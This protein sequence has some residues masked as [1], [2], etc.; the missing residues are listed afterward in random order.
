MTHPNPSTALARVV[1]DEMANQGVE[2]VVISPGSR[3]AAVAI[4]ASGD[5]SVETI[6]VVD[7]RSAA[8]HALGVARATGRP[9]AVLSTS[10]T[11]P[12]NFFPAIVEADMSCVPMVVITADRPAEMQGLGANQTIDQVE[13]FGGKVRAYS[14][15]EAPD[16]SVDRNA[17]WR[18][19][20]GRVVSAARGPR[21]GPAHLNVRFREPTVPVTDDGRTTESEYPFPTPRVDGP[22]PGAPMGPV[23]M[24]VLAP[25]RGIVIAGD[26][27]YDREALM[28]RATA[29]NW[30]VLATALSGMRGDAVVTTYHHLLA[31]GVEEALRPDTVVAVGAIG[32]SHRLESL[33][34]SARDRVRIDLWGRTIDPH[35][36][37]TRDI[38]G[39]VGR[40][41]QRVTGPAGEDWAAGWEDAEKRCRERLEGL[42]VADHSM[43]GAAVASAL[44][45]V[46]WGSLVVASSLP[47][48]EVDSHLRRGGPVLANRGASGIDGFVSTALG[49]ASCIPRTLALCGDLSLLHD[50]NGFINDGDLD[51]TVVVIDNGG[52]GIFDSLPQASHAPDYERLFVTPPHRDFETLARL[53][54][55]RFAEASARH[56][57][58]SL[59]RE[60]LRRPG[61][62]LIRVPIDRSHDLKVRSQLD[63]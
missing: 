8:F 53:H 63:G 7:E 29:L 14:G 57:L 34:A 27:D 22:L 9:A 41:L 61:L 54:G 26:G 18:G 11:A 46:D 52:G 32:P 12:A 15:I 37:A 56:D 20:V 48:R 62:D 55:L 5:D 35:R 45:D 2:K 38:A 28:V 24:P 58:V 31:G 51:L 47:I 59:T 42:L 39:D 21:P 3:S 50:S 30:P 49:V 13:M 40:L 33:I 60:A 19:V 16:P 36:N 25:D 44:N 23:E 43:S 4:A 1:V 17:E 6:V 10:G